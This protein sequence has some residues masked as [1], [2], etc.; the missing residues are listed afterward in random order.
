MNSLFKRRLLIFAAL[1]LFI[2][3]MSFVFYHGISLISYINISFYLSSILLLLGL[4]LYTISSGFFDVFSK[5][6]NLVFSRGQGKRKF[7]EVPSLSE[8][9][10]M[11]QK[12]LFFYGLTIGFFMIIALIVFYF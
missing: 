7:H 5:S 9:I 8:L 3:S 4:L 12:P 6:F 10:T 11:D 2:I 1:Q